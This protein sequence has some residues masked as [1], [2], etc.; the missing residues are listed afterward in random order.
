[1]TGP[2]QVLKYLARYTH[3]VA[4][5]NGRLRSLQDGLLRLRFRNSK[6]NNRIET[7]AL[8]AV[9]F[10]RRFLLHVLPRGFI[11]IRYYG[12][13]SH[14]KR[15]AGLVRCRQL[16]PLSGTAAA[17]A[18]VLSKV[19]RRAVERRCPRCRQ[20]RLRISS[21]GSRRSNSN[22]ASATSLCP[23]YP[24]PRPSIPPEISASTSQINAA[25]H[26]PT[27]ALSTPAPSSSCGADSTGFESS[28]ASTNHQ[29]LA[30]PSHVRRP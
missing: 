30:D 16:L 19:Q 2:E 14:P 23:T 29:S 26:R 27:T 17:S 3:R 18:A 1:M 8:D 10:L 6:N 28:I 20:G 22:C 7:L 4:I 13:L 11:K 12:F 15:A 24:G 9:E 25:T 5:S 21:N